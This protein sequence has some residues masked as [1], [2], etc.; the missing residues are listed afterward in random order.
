MVSTSC[1]AVGA[2]ASCT[3][4]DDEDNDCYSLCD[5]GTFNQNCDECSWKC[6]YCKDDADTCT[7]CNTESGVI[8]TAP[9]CNCGDDTIEISDECQPCHDSCAICTDLSNV[10]CDACSKGYYLLGGNTCVEECPY[11]YIPET[12]QDLCHFDTDS[13]VN[14]VV[15]V[16]ALN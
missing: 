7:E 14:P 8:G 10:N 16:D 5:F 12:D 15:S 3:V 1:S 4:C 9:T 2:T 6:K 13:L 11:G